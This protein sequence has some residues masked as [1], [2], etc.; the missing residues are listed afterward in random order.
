MRWLLLL[1]TLPGAHD[2]GSID[3]LNDCVQQRFQRPAPD[4]GMSRILIPSS[5]GR[6]FAPRPLSTRDFVPENDRERAVIAKLESESVQVGFYLFGRPILDAPAAA[7]NPRAL[8][9]PG[10]MTAGT[11]RV[12]AGG[13]VPDG[14]PDLATIYPLAQRT[15]QSFAE[16]G[17]GF[18]TIA[19]SW[20]IAA[21]PVLA[22]QERC[23][24]CHKDSA[25]RQAVGGVLYAY[26][27]KQ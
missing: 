23:M 1:L 25:M 24:S 20:R 21:R 11:P 17:S 5:M 12:V 2:L 8:K 9:G 4:F 10:V 27:R 13:L 18:E 15:M 14:L 19:G 16:G 6:H 22:E 3:L 7:L 26:R